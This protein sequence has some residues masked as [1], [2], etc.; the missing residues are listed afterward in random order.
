[1]SAKASLVEEWIKKADHDLGV[2]GLTLEHGPQFI[3]AICFH[4]QQAVEKYLKGYLTHLDIVFRKTHSLVYL[5]DLLVDLEPVSQ[6]VYGKAEK[7]E[8]YAV[9]LRYPDSRHEPTLEE[10]REAYEIAG[11]FRTMVLEKMGK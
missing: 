10:A 6:E 5:L 2:A 8:G 11:W 9:E 7:L 3:D 1:M 4:S